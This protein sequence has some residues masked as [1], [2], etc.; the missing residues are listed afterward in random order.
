VLAELCVFREGDEFAISLF[1]DFLF[2]LMAASV[3]EA[4]EEPE[5]CL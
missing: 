5:G 4:L 1:R 3:D 2:P